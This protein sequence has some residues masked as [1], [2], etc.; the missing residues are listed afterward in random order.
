MFMPARWKR[1]A[2]RARVVVAIGLLVHALGCG[3]A[4]PK[5]HPVRGKVELAGAEVEKLAGSHVEAALQSDMTVR[6]SGEIQ[7]DG[8]F[9]LES[10][11]ASKRVDGALAG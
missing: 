1:S 11:Q 2:A 7:K 9:T 8:S 5:S 6:A 3:A 10:L 4:G